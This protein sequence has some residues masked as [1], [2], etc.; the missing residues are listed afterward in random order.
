MFWNE[1]LLHFLFFFFLFF[2]LSY[3]IFF[4]G[5]IFLSRKQFISLFCVHCLKT[6]ART[7]V[8]GVFLNVFF[9]STLTYVFTPLK[10]ILSSSSTR[11]QRIVSI[12]SFFQTDSDNLRAWIRYLYTCQIIDILS[13]LFLCCRL[14]VKKKTQWRQSFESGCSCV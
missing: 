13:T 1:K 8:R 14:M 4:I 2:I 7:Y 3:M 10:Y 12:G 6:Y 9:F 5:P 11:I